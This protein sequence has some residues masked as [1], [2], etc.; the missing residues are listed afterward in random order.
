MKSSTDLSSTAVKIFP[1]RAGFHG[2]WIRCERHAQPAKGYFPSPQKS[3]Q[4][5]D[6][7][8]SQLS[9]AQMPKLP[10]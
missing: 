4:V 1:R 7:E 2:T 3:P 9:F 8:V 5:D 10:Q 6:P